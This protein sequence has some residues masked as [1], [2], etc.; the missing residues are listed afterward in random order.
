MVSNGFDEGVVDSIEAADIGGDPKKA[1]FIYTGK[2]YGGRE[3]TSLVA[4]LDPEKHHFLRIGWQSEADDH[5]DDYPVME[6]LGVMEC[7]DDMS[8]CKSADAG[9]IFAYGDAFEQT[10]NIFDYLS[11]DID[12][13]IVTD[14]KTEYG[15]LHDMK[16]DLDGIYWVRNTKRGIAKFL[17]V[18]EPVKRKRSQQ[19]RFSRLNSTKVLFPLLVFRKAVK[20]LEF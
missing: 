6:R 15:N 20:S 19:N 17:R 11:A 7:R 13:I 9:V 4:G 2:F 14:G 1:K 8:H 18:Y 10:T 16:K 3:A 12:I 5:L